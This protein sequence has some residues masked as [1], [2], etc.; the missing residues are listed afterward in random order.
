MTEP[1]RIRTLVAEDEIPARR[2]M[3]ELLDEDPEIEVVGEAWGPAA[4]DAI[5]ETRPDLLL[6]DVRMP[7]MDGFELLRS[8]ESEETPF[9]VF[10]TAYDEYA[11]DA[12]DVRAI[13]YLLKPFS[14]ERFRAALALAKDRMRAGERGSAAAE[15]GR[16]R[17]D[18]GAEGGEAALTEGARDR[19]VLREGSRLLA[20]P[21]AEIRWIEASGL[22]VQI[23]AAAGRPH[24]VRCS[25]NSLSRMLR[26]RG[27]HR[28]HRSAI[29]NLELVREVQPLSHGDAVVLLA[30]GTR[31]KLSRSR[32]EEVE[33]ILGGE[34]DR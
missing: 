12:F 15:L 7:G 20:I 13:D 24:L 17:R 3:R 14:D 2:L 30:D 23:H 6:L 31:L 4:L 32:R 10:V 1:T 25:M 8:L 19:L 33:R 34:Q 5:R 27:F 29:V 11:V 28:I 18:E 16:N 26:P 21:H 22:Y 9:V